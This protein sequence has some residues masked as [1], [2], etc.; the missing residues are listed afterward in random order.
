MEGGKERPADMRDREV[1]GAITEMID[2]IVSGRLM[3]GKGMRAAYFRTTAGLLVDLEPTDAR[4]A[5]RMK[6]IHLL[7]DTKDLLLREL[8]ME[9]ANGDNTV[10]RFTGARAGAPLPANTFQLP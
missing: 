10:T 6:G 1:Y 5:K 7:F 4:V 2:G 8:R 9:Q 3:N